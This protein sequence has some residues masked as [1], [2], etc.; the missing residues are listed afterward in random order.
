MSTN[1]EL[2]K[3]IAKLTK[4][5][6][7]LNIENGRFQEDLLEE[8]SRSHRIRNEN[9]EFFATSITKCRDEIC[10][11]KKDID[12]KQTHIESLTAKINVLIDEKREETTRNRRQVE[13]HQDEVKQICHDFG[14]RMQDM[15]D[16]HEGSIRAL[17]QSSTS[18]KEE[19]SVMRQKIRD[20]TAQINNLNDSH[21]EQ[22]ASIIKKHERELYSI[23]C[24]NDRE[25]EEL[26][27]TTEDDRRRSMDHLQSK[28]KSEIDE[29]ERQYKLREKQMTK[30]HLDEIE[31][32]KT[33]KTAMQAE[34]EQNNQQELKKV[35]EIIKQ[36]DV[37]IKAA[38]LSLTREI[39]LGKLRT[40]EVNNE[41]TR[42]RIEL[43]SKQDSLLSSEMTVSKFREKVSS[44]YISKRRSKGHLQ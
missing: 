5:I 1:H 21:D 36:K 27:F 31:V 23:R 15:K 17:S 11:L 29:R 33:T 16:R 19:L 12:A 2:Y 20:Q 39:D 8:R 10:K 37:T 32:L 35:H 6:Y 41:L 13:T 7:N 28:H 42:A 14:K 24:K 43:K 34:I 38:E 4:V 30:L 40:Q 22:I 44:S 3:K 26:K 25:I 18:L 9:E